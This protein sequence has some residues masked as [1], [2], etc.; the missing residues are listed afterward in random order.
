ET[1][2]PTVSMIAKMAPNASA[3]LRMLNRAVQLK[4]LSNIIISPP[5]FE[6]MYGRGIPECLPRRVFAINHRGI[7]ECLPRRVFAINHR[8][9]HSGLPL[10]CDLKNARSGRI[11][12]AESAKSGCAGTTPGAGDLAPS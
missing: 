5:R 4:F 2:A 9:R 8:G 11:G 10:L 3:R 1:P 6:C 7:P 12:L